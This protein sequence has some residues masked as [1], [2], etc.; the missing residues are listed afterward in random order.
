MTLLTTVL[1]LLTL[2]A[3]AG[4]IARWWPRVPLPLLQLALGAICG[5][6]RSGI[7]LALEPQVFMLLFIPPMLFAD[8]WLISK[9]ELGAQSLPVLALSVGLVLATVL[10]GGWGIAWLVP[11]LPLPMAFLLAA[12]LSPTDAVAVSAMAQRQRLPAR[13]QNILEGESL[14]NDASALVA[15]KFALAAVMAQAF[16]PMGAVADFVVMAAGGI[17]VGLLCSVVFDLLQ[18]VLLRGREHR[19]EMPTVLLLLL[20]PFA[21]YLL[22]EHLH[23]SG[24]LAAVAA[25][26]GASLLAV[27]RSGFNASHVRTRATGAVVRYV[28]DG[29]VF[30]LLGLQLSGILRALPNQ[31]NL[32]DSPFSPS[33]LRLWGT[34]LAILVLLLAVRFAGFVAAGLARR[35][36]PWLRRRSSGAPMS[37]AMAAVGAIGGVRG[38]ITL[39]A[40]LGVPLTMADGS[41]FAMRGLMVFLS[42]LVIVLSMALATIALP[43]LLRRVGH[44]GAEAHGDRELLW[45]RRCSARAAL[46]ALGVAAERPE[47]DDQRELHQGI[48]ERIDHGYRHRLRQDGPDADGRLRSR[49]L[50]ALELRLRLELLQVERRELAR[51]R[52]RHRINDETLRTLTHELD[53]V[54]AAIRNAH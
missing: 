51:L 53:L 41:P 4:F 17:A 5:W 43:P 20:T 26:V 19:M 1:A 47:H 49:Q 32:L 39:V 33:A 13:L 48:C 7:H 27:R 14:M 44:D 21:P 36:V 15:V 40:V 50:I 34:G 10:I 46:R 3:V 31:L 25:G 52:L 37:L 42:G 22:A 18:A 2:V 45:A 16:S 24:V 6:P 28:F 9:R 12:V 35:H 8:G 29:L 30:L 54:E 38:A 23:L 11:V